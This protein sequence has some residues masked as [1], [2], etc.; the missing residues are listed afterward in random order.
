[1]ALEQLAHGRGNGRRGGLRVGERG[2]DARG[3]EDAVAAPG[4]V[5][6]PGDRMG[7]GA[8]AR[9]QEVRDL[10]RRPPAHV[11]KLVARG[12]GP[13]LLELDEVG[14]RLRKPHEAGGH[15]RPGG[16]HRELR[17]YRQAPGLQLGRKRAPG[18][19][20]VGR[21][22]HH[23]QGPLAGKPQYVPADQLVHGERT[24]RLEQ[25]HGPA[26]LERPRLVRTEQ[27]IHEILELGGSPG[28]RT[29]AAG[30]DSRVRRLGRNVLD[31]NP[32]RMGR[33]RKLRL[34]TR[35]QLARRTHA[36]GHEEREVGPLGNRKGKLPC[37]PR[38][39]AKPGHH[40]GSKLGSLPPHEAGQARERLARLHE[41][42]LAKQ[43]AIVAGKLEGPPLAGGEPVRRLVCGQPGQAPGRKLAEYLDRAIAR[44]ERG[45]VAPL[46]QTR[47]EHGA[48]RRRDHRA[49]IT[50]EAPAQ[51]GPGI[52]RGAGHAHSQP[53]LRGQLALGPKR[54]GQAWREQHGRAT[55]GQRAPQQGHD[56][57][58]HETFVARV[59]KLQCHVPS[60]LAARRCRPP[61]DTSILPPLADKK[62]PS[63]KL[64]VNSLICSPFLPGGTGRPGQARLL[65]YGRPTA[66]P[67]QPCRPRPRPYGR[68]WSSTLL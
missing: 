50:I 54:H 24:R 16:R 65:P 6:A 14:D 45:H 11:G 15:A 48:N 30:N 64:E 58:R 34:G 56:L 39:L 20:D 49:A 2:Q 19:R 43:L 23:A 22:H 61:I 59:Y 62:R 17:A 7:R 35:R 32:P 46:E 60:P 51:T 63:R 52:R 41:A 53:R 12:V 21:D 33:G 55:G 57:G 10:A 1:M 3:G 66:T 26:R 25:P 44:I 38:H 27:R 67:D 37:G 29:H 13:G 40:E 42:A 4:G 28:R 68:R 8:H 47:H 36:V 5:A 18:S 31:G 9:E